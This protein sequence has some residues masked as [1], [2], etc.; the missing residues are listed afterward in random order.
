MGGGGREGAK[1]EG[2]GRGE[3]DMVGGPTLKPGAEKWRGWDDAVRLE[4]GTG[5]TV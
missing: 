4:Y 5:S 1:Q 2:E 3:G